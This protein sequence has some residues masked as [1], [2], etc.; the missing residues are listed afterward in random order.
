MKG[1][2]R[3]IAALCFLCLGTALAAAGCNGNKGN[4]PTDTD[5]PPVISVE[6]DK[7][8]AGTY[9]VGQT[10]TLPR[11]SAADEEDGDVSSSIKLRVLFN[12][13]DEY[14]L[15]DGEDEE[16]K[17][18]TLVQFT[19]E[20]CGKYTAI[21]TV[22]DKG[23][24]T[25]REEIAFTVVADGVENIE[26]ARIQALEGRLDADREYRVRRRRQR[27]VRQHEERLARL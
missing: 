27:R 11:A 4:K 6:K 15:F 12:R 25:T 16:V 10:I 26:N 8:S 23:G 9:V 17:G 21:Y 3:V 20:K 22:R 18:N 5:V 14:I 7:F 2:K 13:D 19:P 1:K 24:N